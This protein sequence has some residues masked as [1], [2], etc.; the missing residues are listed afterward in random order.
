MMSVTHSSACDYRLT[1]PGEF[2]VHKDAFVHQSYAFI[3]RELKLDQK[4]FHL[5]KK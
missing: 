4:H 1:V 3:D 2:E 5:E